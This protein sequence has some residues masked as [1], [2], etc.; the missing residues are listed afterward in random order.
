MAGGNEFSFQIKGLRDLMQTLD[1]FPEKVSGTRLR[2]AT[3]D[4]VKPVVAMAKAT[5]P[6]GRAAEGAAGEH[7]VLRN[8]KKG[9]EG[10]KVPMPHAV[11]QIKTKSKIGRDKLSAYTLV[12]VGKSAYYATIFVE[13]GTSRQPKQAWLRPAF[14]AT[15]SEQLSRMKTRMQRI[16]SLETRKAARRNTGKGD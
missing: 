12:G 6:Q 4:A 7:Y 15:A 11:G 3:K 10:Y 1:T 13:L 5:I 9:K 2:D 8:K 14:M 16:I